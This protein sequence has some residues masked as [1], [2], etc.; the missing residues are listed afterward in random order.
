MQKI[1]LRQEFCQQLRVT[2]IYLTNRQT[3]LSKAGMSAQDCSVRHSIQSSLTTHQGQTVQGL[4][5]TAV[6]AES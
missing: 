5:S 6:L 1:L 2:F 3:R 4:G